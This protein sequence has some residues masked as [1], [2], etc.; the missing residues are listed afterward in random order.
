MYEKTEKKMA[1]MGAWI[2]THA[3]TTIM[4]SLLFTA[5]FIVHVPQ[6]KFDTSNEGFF[7]DDDPILISYNKFREQ[8]GRDERIAVAIESAKI[9]TLEF[10]KTLRA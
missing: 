4:L 7:H 3:L 10:L 8:F 9:F 1:R 2:A 6:I 5:I